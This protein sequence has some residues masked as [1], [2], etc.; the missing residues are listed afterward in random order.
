MDLEMMTNFNA[1]ERELED[2]KK[3]FSRADPRLVLQSV[4]TPSGSVMSVM[5]L[6]LE[7]QTS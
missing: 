7:D 6:V 2:W 3:L 4:A 5:E 1:S